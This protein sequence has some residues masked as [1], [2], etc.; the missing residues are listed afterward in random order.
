MVG[1]SAAVK[2]LCV[3]ALS[4]GSDA[5]YTFVPPPAVTVAAAFVTFCVRDDDVLVL[6]FESPE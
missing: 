2:P 3:V 4:A 1:A 6:K 5:P